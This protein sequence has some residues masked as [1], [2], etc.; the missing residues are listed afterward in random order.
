MATISLETS[1][2]F[3]ETATDLKIDKNILADYIL[4][5]VCHP[6]R[7]D[8]VLRLYL[9]Q[10]MLYKY[11]EKEILDMPSKEIYVDW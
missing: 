9:E 11:T 5:Y 8:L 10:K 6:E 1:K 3:Q 2:H 4:G 7:R